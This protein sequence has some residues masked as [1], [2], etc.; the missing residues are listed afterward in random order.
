MNPHRLL[1]ILLLL[2]PGLFLFP[3][4]TKAQ[5]Y[6]PFDGAATSFHVNLSRY[7]ETPA[8]EQISRKPSLDSVKAFIADEKWDLTNLNAHL[9]LYEKLLI[10]VNRHYAYFRLKAYKDN[11]DTSA[12]KAKQELEDAEGNLNTRVSLQ[13]QQPLFIALDA[14]KLSAN[15]LSKYTYL[16]RKAKEQAAHTLSIRDEEIIG[17][18]NDPMINRLTD[19]YDHL[20]DNIKAND[21]Q[22]ADNKMIN[23]VNNRR[24]VLRNPDPVVRAACSKAYYAAYG[25]H[26]E[27]L[28]ATLVDIASQKNTTAKLHGF[29]SAPEATYAHRLQLQEDS[30]RSMLKEMTIHA[31][32]L[33]EYQQLQAAQVK[34]K[35]GLAEVHSWDLYL[36]TDFSWKP[37][38]Y[39]Q[40]KDI[41]LTSFK[42]L[43]ASYQNVFA[44][45]LNPANGALDIAGG[46]WRV[47]EYT[48]VGYP[49]I[50]TT[51][52]MR[53]YRGELAEV[54]R[55]SHEGGHAIH[56]QLMSDQHIV[57]SY[58]LGPSYLFEAYAML[59]ELLV[60]D[61]LQKQATTV[62]AKAYFTKQFLDKLSLEVFTSAE[63]GAFEQ[64]IYDGAATGGINNRADVDSLYSG[65]VQQ[66][67][68]FF[69]AEP[70]RKSEWIN[71]RLLFD[72]PL[73]NVN[74]LYAI[75]ISCKLYQQAHDDPT[76]FAAQYAA[77]LKNGFDAPAQALLKKYM[78]FDLDNQTL[79]NSTL[80]LMERKIKE[81]KGLYDEMNKASK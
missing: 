40:V 74:Y 41:I 3:G 24:E 32:V 8:A 11:R 57:P 29:K 4:K 60:L 42:P 30:V 25:E 36:P 33:K 35:T 20:M 64:G 71:K 19:R 66:Y 77:L 45:L 14:G 43:G 46:A 58:S 16:F 69:T 73:Y 51:L 56:A 50:P 54:L 38:P 80:G 78:G 81:L 7:F 72:D 2:I 27:L 37:L 48:S 47:N 76:H 52:Y 23:P 53:S 26:A 21:I 28:A 55:L 6:D 61:E 18:L 79:L 49:G 63:E 65:I 75:L 5:T 12:K 9:A 44:W 22:L 10:S 70:E 68:L 34:L 31:A 15:G 1:I 59:N 62:Y 39:S 67:D 17:K 13:L